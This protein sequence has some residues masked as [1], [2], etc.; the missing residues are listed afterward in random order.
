MNQKTTPQRYGKN[1]EM[2]PDWVSIQVPT[3]LAGTLEGFV[4]HKKHRLDDLL[5][6]L[7]ED[8]FNALTSLIDDPHHE[9]KYFDSML[10]E[11]LAGLSLS[12]DNVIESEHV[13]LFN[14]INN[15]FQSCIEYQQKLAKEGGRDE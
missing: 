9:K 3:E 14:G 7:S 11:F 15:L 8:V 10:F 6:L 5:M 13:T 4:K 12:T 1:T 2:Q